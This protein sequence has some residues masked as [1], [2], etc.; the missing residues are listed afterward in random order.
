MNTLAAFLFIFST[1]SVNP[2]ENI[3]V[4]NLTSAEKEYIVDQEARS[5]ILA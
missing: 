4:K 2:Y 1:A 3:D 5:K